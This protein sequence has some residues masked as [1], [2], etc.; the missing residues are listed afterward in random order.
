MALD[1]STSP[2]KMPLLLYFKW[3]AVVLWEFFAGSAN[4]HLKRKSGS[5][6]CQVGKGIQVHGVTWARPQND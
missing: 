1:K 4:F 2:P 3:S 5:I 6:G